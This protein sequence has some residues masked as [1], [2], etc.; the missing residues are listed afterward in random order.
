MPSLEDLKV[1]P[2]AWHA[3]SASEILKELKSSLKGL[4]EQSVLVRLVRVGPNSLPERRQPGAL[5][6]FFN[7]FKS[8][9]VIILLVAAV[10]TLALQDWLDGFVILVA[11]A[12][13]AAVGFVQEYKAAN[14]LKELQN[15][16]E[17][18]ARLKRDGR[19]TAVLVKDLV[20][21]DIIYLQPG[22]KVPADA[23]LLQATELEANEAALTGESEPIKKKIGKLTATTVMA[24]RFNM[25][26]QGS[27]ITRGRAL[28][29][30]VATGYHTQLGNI[31]QLLLAV[32]ETDTP[33]QVKLARLAKYIG[34]IVMFVCLGIL[35][36]GLSFSY[37]FQ[38]MFTLAVAIAVSAVPEGL[39]V[40]VTAILALGMRRILKRQS[41]VRKLVAAET[42]G[43][44]TV[45]CADKT[46]TLTAGQ[47]KVSQLVLPNLEGWP[48]V[49]PLSENITAQNLLLAGVMVSD[50]YKEY[51]TQSGEYFVVGSP[52]ERA[53]YLAA[54]EQGI[55]IEQSRA[56]Q[57]QIKVLPFNSERK[58]MASLHKKDKE[59]I[60]YVKGAPERLL[61]RCVDLEIT[62]GIVKLDQAKKQ[63]FVDLIAKMSGQG[64]RLLALTKRTLKTVVA[65]KF[66]LTEDNLSNLTLLGLAVLNDPLRVGVGDTLLKAKRAGLRI[67]MITGDHKLT[68]QAI[69]IQAGLKAESNNIL[70]GYELA[71]LTAEDLAISLKEISVIARATPQDKLNIV[72]ALQG[73]GEVVAMTGDG[74][75][76]APALQAADIGISFGAGTDVAREASD[77][78]LLNNDISTIVA[79]VEEGR[80]IY[81]NIRK[82]LLYLMS[83]SFAEV[84]LIVGALLWSLVRGG[85]VW[86][87]LLATQ[88]L[89]INLV[90]DTF[91]ALALAS[92]PGRPEIMEQPP[93]SRQQ[94]ILDL[95]DRLVIAGISLLKGLGALVIFMVLTG[96]LMSEDTVR[97]IIFS[98]MAVSTPLYA[99]SLKQFGVPLWHK[100]NWNNRSLVGAVLLSLGL[101]LLVVYWTPLQKVFYTVPLTLEHWSIVLFFTLF[102]IAVLEVVKFIF[103]KSK[104]LSVPS[105]V[106]SI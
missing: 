55:L 52:T 13:N 84:V 24:E 57:P 102:L 45:I 93:I 4:S 79:A 36:L 14:A 22:D 105:S 61:E 18:Y 27:T 104:K 7:Q 44:T 21:G 29:V 56:S 25:V 106:S 28:A 100:S 8:A 85:P 15:Y 2:K 47:M 49:Q 66:I 68:A 62:S 58:L 10:V 43:S 94:P 73:Q 81:N 46:G 11:V 16:V 32:K 60:L 31:A 98:L 92:D 6:L 74:V 69:A 77:M 70:D 23:R 5:S 54:E 39:V 78:V 99:F 88:I 17:D 37:S 91:P 82:V 86:L 96:W 42:L 67:I 12:I 59:V 95:K 75:N 64:Y 76:D 3:L 34:L 103:F 80:T 51:K 89:W 53:L 41:L 97:T 40:L 9:L 26:Y 50:A 87:P 19:N 101:Q 33:L 63:A 83:D 35:L 90:A 72:R 65:K 30:V 71:D 1:V 48:E 38:Q 20:P